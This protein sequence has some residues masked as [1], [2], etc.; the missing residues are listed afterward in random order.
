MANE[1]AKK[2]VRENAATLKWLGSV[3]AAAAVR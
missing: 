3:A 1:S 2:R